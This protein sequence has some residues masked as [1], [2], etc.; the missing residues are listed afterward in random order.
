MMNKIFIKLHLLFIVPFVIFTAID[1]VSTYIAIHH[2]GASELN[3]FTNTESL[4][5]LIIPEI[6]ILIVGIICVSV[7]CKVN[8]DFL[9]GDINWEIKSRE[10]FG[11]R[12]VSLK[13]SLVFAPILIAF[14]R[15]FAG[16]NNIMV[17]FFG[18]GITSFPTEMLHYLVGIPRQMANLMVLY[19]LYYSFNK[20]FVKIIFKII[21][22]P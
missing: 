22:S 1:N 8:K 4:A 13:R 17:I 7:G 18:N 12:L 10:I 21:Y 11:W 20:K 2:Y 6:Y 3:P 16:A 9:E 5:T 19:I 14:F 15:G